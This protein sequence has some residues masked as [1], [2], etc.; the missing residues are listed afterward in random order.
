[1]A[2][3]CGLSFASAAASSLQAQAPVHRGFS[4]NRDVAIRIFVPTGRVRIV[5]WEHDSIDVTGTVGKNSSFHGG[6]GGAGAKIFVEPRVPNDS[7]LPD[8]NLTVSVP[9]RA[10]VWVK[11]TMGTIDAAG[12]TGEL[13][14]YTVGGSITVERASGVVSTESID[15]PVTISRST[16]A[17][18]VRN[19]K[20]RVRLNDVTGTLSIATVSG[21]VEIRG[22]TAPEA[23]VETIG[24]SIVLEAARF[25]G[26][27]VDLQTHSGDITIVASDRYMPQ[28]DLV[29]R[30]GSVTKPVPIGNP[31]EGRVIARSFKGAINVKSA[32]GIEKGK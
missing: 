30:G 12:T 27:L 11:M 26:T 18:R 1:M 5:A 17:I 29:S 8:G 24:G 13:E 15:A 7:V 22:S 25:G 19:G 32:S 14:L 28:F 20:G 4:A 16:G 9:K 21:P 10:R 31:K 2:C 6:G 23:R 3:A